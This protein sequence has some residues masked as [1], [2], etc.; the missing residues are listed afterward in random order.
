MATTAKRGKGNARRNMTQERNEQDG[1][2]SRTKAGR[3]GQRQTRE[4][5]TRDQDGVWCMD[6]QH[7]INLLTQL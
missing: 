5:R 4:G 7:L 6:F 3:A 1:A 2:G